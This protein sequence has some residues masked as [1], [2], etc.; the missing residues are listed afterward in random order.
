MINKSVNNDMGL[1]KY[2][3][4]LI[5]VVFVMGF[6]HSF[7]YKFF[8]PDDAFIY[9]VYVNSFLGGDG[10]TFN[11]QLVE[12]Y[13]SIL[14]LLLVAALS[15]LGADPLLAA[16]CLGWIAYL[17][18]GGLLAWVHRL[19]AS[20][21]RHVYLTTLI[22]YF[23]LPTLAMWAAGA[24]EAMLF[25]SLILAA[26][27]SYFY[28]RIINPSNT[29]A[30]LSGVLFG[31]VSM[32]RPEGF[33]LVG[34]VVGFEV[35]LFFHGRKIRFN[36][37]LS[38]LFC[39][40]VITGVMFLGR[41]SIYGELFPVTVG[42]KTGNLA[43]QMQLGST[44]VINFV[45]EYLLLSA[46]YVFATVFMLFRGRK[47]TEQYFLVWLSLI[48]VSGYL[49]FNLLVGGD[50]MLG[51]RFLVPILPF[52]ALTIGLALGNIHKNISAV[53]LSILVVTLILESI[54]LYPVSYQQAESD[55][56]DIL[57]GRYIKTLG[58]PSSEK[59]A[60]IDAGAIPYYAEL[61]TIDMI[62]LNDLHIS[63]LPGGF[64]QKYDNDYVLNQKPKIIQFHT[65]YINQLGDVAPTEAFRGSLVLF[66]TP[67]FQKWY[68]R[69]RNS[70]VP[71]LFTRRNAPLEH[72]F[73]DTYFDAD[74]S[75]NLVSSGKLN[76]SLK[77]TGDGTWLPQKKDHREAGAV[78][79]HITATKSN[80]QVIYEDYESIPKEMNKGDVVMVSLSLPD[81]GVD[82]YRLIVC[83][84]LLGVRDFELCRHGGLQYSFN[85][86]E[87]QPVGEGTIYFTDERLT[88]QGW[89]Q[90]E[91][92]FIW[93]LGYDSFIEF[94]S[95]DM[96]Q[97]KSMSIDLGVFGNQSLDVYLND[98]LVYS[99]A[100]FTGSLIELTD[101]EL[102]KGK[103]TIRFFHP[104]AK[105]PASSDNRVIAIALKSFELKK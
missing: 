42:A 11:G 50:W 18:G 41:W 31:L 8:Q 80:G 30:V 32:T 12:G 19:V 83:P 98:E 95:I 76:V 57:M 36:T 27:L 24:M 96:E 14:W 62:G 91:S 40:V 82:N 90:P 55:K 89:S 21:D 29:A 100:S 53:F 4:L 25:A 77:K 59:I 94:N 56:G 103:N 65:K 85:T 35:I 86:E 79:F 17:L 75:G 101:V 104:K 49:L 61:P 26:A 5:L 51:W 92:V 28:A 2:V 73:L 54:S 70:P 45:K 43:W 105:S 64:L 88:L 81:L 15:W 20:D 3:P 69:D 10:L 102:A 71:H 37:I 84:T 6:L 34:T 7:L 74:I 46:M 23:L 48:V 1:I 33:A 47:N 52:L 16:K 39:Y 44:Y 9:L 93:S 72:T 99:K 13:S 58:L 97:Y 38:S 63:K 78:Y 66:Y 68:E 67:E 22:I 87:I 60:V